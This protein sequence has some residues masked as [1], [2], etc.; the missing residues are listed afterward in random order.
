[1]TAI[2]TVAGMVV[3][4]IGIAAATVVLIRMGDRRWARRVRLA[5]ADHWRGDRQ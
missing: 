5:Q 1:M 3:V 2:L 4:I